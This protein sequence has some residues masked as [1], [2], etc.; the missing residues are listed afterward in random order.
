MSLLYNLS[1]RQLWKKLLTL[2][3]DQVTAYDETIMAMFEAHNFHTQSTEFKPSNYAELMDMM[4]KP[5]PTHTGIML[6]EAYYTE[7]D[8]AIQGASSE[9]KVNSD[10]LPYFDVLRRHDNLMDRVCSNWAPLWDKS[11]LSAPVPDLADGISIFNAGDD[12]ELLRAQLDR[13]IVP[14]HREPF[15]SNFFLEFKRPMADAETGARQ[16]Q[17]DGA[18]G[19]RGI[20]H[21]RILNG[22]NINDEKA[23]AFSATYVAGTLALYAHFLK[24][25][26][27]SEK[28]WHYH[29][30]R[31]DVHAS[32]GSLEKLVAAA[33]A[34][35]NLRDYAAEIR[36]KL[37]KEVSVKLR[38][39]E[40]LPPKPI[41]FLTLKEA[42]AE[43]RRKAQGSK[44]K[45]ARGK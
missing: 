41:Y 14:I 18:V 31:L 17:H 45:K 28:D 38:Q 44:N 36:I 29:M 43:E 13:Y 35:R 21:T 16:A 25:A 11:P 27:P 19:L 2:I 8:R 20:A 5:H 1:C 4:K 7:F 32:S 22:E 15:L 26:G 37:A 23:V 33:R 40:K 9:S 3:G 24:R 10:V 12:Y 42:E 34:F 39:M 30:C 6:D